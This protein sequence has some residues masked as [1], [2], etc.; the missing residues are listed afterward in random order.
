MGCPNLNTEYYANIAGNG[1]HFIR[2][3]DDSPTS[4]SLPVR[5]DFPTFYRTFTYDNMQQIKHIE[6][7]DF[8][9]KSLRSLDF[10]YDVLGKVTSVTDKAGGVRSNTYD[11]LGRLTKTVGINGDVTEFKFDARNN[12]I[13]LKSARGGISHYEYDA[14]NRMTKATTPEGKITTYSYGKETVDGQNFRISSETLPGGE[15]SVSW[16]NADGLLV[17]REFYRSDASLESTSQYT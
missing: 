7:F 1:F 12:M 14:A 2:P 16:R 9:D 10:A 3:Y 4:S 17:K 8:T 13:E 6:E 15:K 11:V 5:V